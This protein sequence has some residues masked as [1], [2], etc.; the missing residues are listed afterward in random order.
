TVGWVPRRAGERG[1]VEAGALPALLPGG[2]PVSDAEARTEMARAWGVSVLPDAPGRDTGEILAAASR[3]ELGA[4]LVGGVDPDDLPDPAAALAALDAVPFLV[5]LELRS[6]AVTDR[7]DVVLPVAA[8]VEKAGTFVDWEGRQ[9]PFEAALPELPAMPDV[10][11]LHVLADAMDVHLGLPDVTR[12]RREIAALQ[13]WP[14]A[15]PEF[16]SVPGGLRRP[17]ER[18]QVVLATWHELLDAG[19]MQ[20]NEEHLAGTARRPVARMSVATA[21]RVGATDRAL[22]T[23]SSTR[24]SVTLPL[25]VTHSMVDD[26]VWLPANARGCA[27]HRDLGVAAGDMVWIDAEESR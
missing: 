16:R 11:V 1:A 5:S 20:D 9:R 8:V 3:G 21:A 7:A 6:S 12:A 4:L 13:P 25:V 26:A 19:R 15:R 2:R 24:G 22:V 27:V 18:G 14:D 10:R 23:V 17:L